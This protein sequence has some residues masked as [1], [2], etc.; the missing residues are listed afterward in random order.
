MSDRAPYPLRSRAASDLHP[1]ALA[2][3]NA[4]LKILKLWVAGCGDEGAVED[5]VLFALLLSFL[6]WGYP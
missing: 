1:L 2:A 5:Q 3:G 6:L 4:I